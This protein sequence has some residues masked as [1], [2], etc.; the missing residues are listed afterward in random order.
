MSAKSKASSGSF[1]KNM[2]IYLPVLV[3]LLY[4]HG[5]TF[6]GAYLGYWGLPPELFKLGFEDT[7]AQGGFSYLIIGLYVFFITPIVAF[8]IQQVAYL[9]NEITKITI[10]KE[11]LGKM[12]DQ[13][14]D[15]QSGHPVP[16]SIGKAAK[17]LGIGTLLAFI[18]VLGILSMF[19]FVNSQGTESAKNQH[20]RLVNSEVKSMILFK[21]EELIGKII[22]CGE[23]FC[24]A[25]ID[26][27]VMILPNDSIQKISR[28]AP[29]LEG[30]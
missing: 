1:L 18:L 24:A 12:E 6:R 13:Q 2:A 14:R 9:I 28:V 26:S 15:N 25:L 21:D 30:G 8:T 16:E 7:I 10:V 5:G 20:E 27:N 4:V 11:F 17:S 29:S 23:Q 22:L 19:E 3:G